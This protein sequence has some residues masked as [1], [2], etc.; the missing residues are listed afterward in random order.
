MGEIKEQSLFK[1]ITKMTM[2]TGF[3]SLAFG[4]VRKIY[5]QTPIENIVS[6]FANDQT[7]F[8]KGVTPQSFGVHI[9][10]DYSLMYWIAR[11]TDV[12]QPIF[13]NT[14]WLPS[15]YLFY[16]PF[17]L[18]PY[19]TGLIV[20]LILMTVSM[21]LPL[22]RE[23]RMSK[24]DFSDIFSALVFLI[25]LSAPF[26]TSIDR[27]NIVGLL[28]IFLYFYFKC[29]DSGDDFS[30]GLALLIACLIKPHAV[31]FGIAL[32]PAKKIKTLITTLVTIAILEISGFAF[33]GGAPFSG[34]KQVV[35]MMGE[36][37][38]FSPFYRG[39]SLSSTLA[40]VSILFSDKTATNFEAWMFLNRNLISIIL[41]VLVGVLACQT[42]LLPSSVRLLLLVLL[43]PIGTPIS[44]SYTS[45]TVFVFLAL[46][47]NESPDELN[48]HHRTYW[49]PSP[50][51]SY[52]TV[53]CS[54]VVMLQLVPIPIAYRGYASIQQPL[55]VI[56]YVLLIC[57]CFAIFVRTYLDMGFKKIMRSRRTEV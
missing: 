31:I 17:T 29:I 9:F 45:V 19:R 16:S 4:A 28:P 46:I 11:S 43:F 48:V 32:I 37:A 57:Q 10:G 7:I 49:K 25:F 20:M 38:N 40:G 5:W 33:S 1:L 47:V 39:N 26:I 21:S 14:P 30:A 3:V 13:F 55:A 36:I 2:V 15:T 42:S 24:S 12:T 52:W 8:P 56:S 18:L 6:Y 34:M 51:N 35:R 50:M 27:G 54:I 22:V 41:V 23:M 53:F 44:N